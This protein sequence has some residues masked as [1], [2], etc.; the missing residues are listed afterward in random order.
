[1]FTG[2]HNSCSHVGHVYRHPQFIMFTSTGIQNSSRSHNGHVYTYTIHTMVMSTHIHNS[3]C[4]HRHPQFMMFTHWPCL[5]TSI[6]HHV[7]TLAM[8]THIHSSSCWHTGHVYT[9]PQ[10]IMLT[11]WPC[12][13]TSTIHHVDINRHPQFIM[14]T[15]WPCLHTST[16]YHVHINRHPEFIMFTHWPCQHTYTI[17]VYIN[18]HPQFIVFTL[19]MSTHIHDTTFTSTDTHHSSCS[20]TG[21]VYRHLGIQNILSFLTKNVHLFTFWPRGSPSKFTILEEWISG[22]LTWDLSLYAKLSD[23]NMCCHFLFLIPF[24][25]SPTHMVLNVHR[26][27]TA[28]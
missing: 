3:S 19:A 25:R 7:H 16:I 17:H 21:H 5:H 15:Y 27:R 9:H 20:H 4:S 6:I 12:L 26:S 24:F 13:H 2:I 23:S 18:R 14:F 10:F 8:F 22:E 28:Y 1:M 11:H